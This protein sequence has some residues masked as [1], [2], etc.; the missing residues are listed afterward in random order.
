MTKDGVSSH[1]QAVDPSWVSSIEFQFYLPGDSYQAHRLKAQS[2]TPSFLPVASPSLLNSDQ[3]APS[4][5]FHDCPWVWLIFKS[6]PRDSGKHVYWF[7]LKNVAKDT[8][9]EMRMV[10]YVERGGEFSCPRHDTLQDP[11]RVPLTAS[12]LNSVLFS[13]YE[14]F[15][16]QA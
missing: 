2:S 14:G 9:E 8:D 4:R 11:P 1:H 7:I 10:R 15:I 16:T 3:L 12:S 13:V 6:S 5:G